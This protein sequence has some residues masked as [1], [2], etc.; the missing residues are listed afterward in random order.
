MWVSELEGGE[1][2]DVV[3]VVRCV[4]ARCRGVDRIALT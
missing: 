3:L 1:E 2:A 4:K